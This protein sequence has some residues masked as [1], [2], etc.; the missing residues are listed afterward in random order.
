MCVMNDFCKTC[1][2]ACVCDTSLTCVGDSGVEGVFVGAWAF[3]HMGDYAMGSG[4]CVAVKRQ[5]LCWE[6]V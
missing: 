3:T 6:M 1:V 2:Y 4:E 5:V